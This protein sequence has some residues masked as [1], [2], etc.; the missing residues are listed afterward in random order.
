[1]N[2]EELNDSTHIRYLLT[3]CVVEFVLLFEEFKND[4]LPNVEPSH[5]VT[6]VLKLFKESVAKI[7]LDRFIRN[8]E[9]AV[10]Q[11]CQVNEMRDE[12]DYQ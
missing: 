2:F 8:L 5:Q 6:I 3:H 10:L 11:Y 1:M 9:K 7:E 12:E 4:T